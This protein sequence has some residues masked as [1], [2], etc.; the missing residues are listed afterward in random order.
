MDRIRHGVIGL[1][2]FGEHHAQMAV[3]LPNV[4]LT[5]VSECRSARLDEV[6]TQYNASKKYTDY[7]ELLADSD[8]DSVSIVTH[9]RDHRDITVEALQA[10]KHVFLEKPMADTVESCQA[11]VDAA[12]QAKGFFM[13]GHICRFDPRVCVA[14]Q[15]IDE[16]RIGNI[17]YMYARRNLSYAIGREV[18]DKI[19]PLIGDGIHD[20]DLMLWLSGAQI[21]TVYAQTVRVA[22]HE[23]PDIGTAMYR[24]DNGATGVIE[25]VWH[26]PENTPYTI[27]AQM[28]IIGTEGAIYIDCGNAGL[29]INDPK[30]LRKPDTGYWPEAHRR[31]VGALRNEMEYFFDCVE[32]NTRPEAIT[33]EESMRAVQVM[34]AAE[35]SAATGQ[36]IRM[37]AP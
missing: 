20:T 30:G 16:G 14:K 25:T 33:P 29:E 18:L 37:D 23:N 31:Q 36:I 32:N 12:N 4:E 26:L 17:T 11:I 9:F 3:S 21:Q 6:A 8:I 34:C 2:F 28:E 15:A 19:S 27:D 1:G 35:K 13:V 24:F 10:G 5:A 7:R 22:D